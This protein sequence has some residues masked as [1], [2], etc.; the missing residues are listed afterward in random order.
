M[1]STKDTA[2]AFSAV[3]D[4][5]RARLVEQVIPSLAV[6]VAREG[7]I[8]WEEGF[9]WADRENRVPATE[10]TIYSLASISKPITATGLMVLK[11]QGKIALDQPIN[12]YLG[13]AK[14]NARVGDAAGATVRRVANHTSGLPLHWQFFYAD[15][16]YR[17]PTMDETILRYGNL[18]TIP[19][20]KSQY[21]NLGF[22][23][24][25]YAMSRAA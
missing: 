5:I 16:P 6:A 25:D 4:L 10:H 11:E 18:V 3:R 20:E 1:P 23:I 19:G 21:S 22:G 7:E 13:E 24:L 17:R 8:L 15:E 12:D 14:L 2:S 9:G